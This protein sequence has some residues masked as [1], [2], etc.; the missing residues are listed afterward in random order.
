MASPAVDKGRF[1]PAL[2]RAMASA[3]LEPAKVLRVAGL[4]SSLHLDASATLSTAQLFAVWK[5]VE[6]LSDDP[7]VALRLLGAADLSG[8]QPAYIAALY[9]ADYRDAIL[10]IERFKRMGLRG[11]SNRGN[12]RMVV[13]HQGMAVRHRA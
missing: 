12:G 6:T 10:R 7:A 3:G 2:W 13:D 11:L 4:A 5:A 1:P 8:H 9:A